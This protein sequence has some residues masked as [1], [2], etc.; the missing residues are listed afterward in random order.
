MA[1]NVIV[2]P[3]TVNEV[4]KPQVL[5]IEPSERVNQISLKYESPVDLKDTAVTFYVMLTVQI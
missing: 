3:T 4:V 1:V 2:F 5:A